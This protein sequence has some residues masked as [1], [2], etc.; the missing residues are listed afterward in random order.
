MFTDTIYWLIIFPNIIHKRGG[1]HVTF[2]NIMPHS[3][4]FI[5][6][7]GDGALNS[8]RYPLFR[9]GYFLLWTSIYVIFQLSLHALSAMIWW[10]YPFLNVSSPW[11][12]LWYVVAGLLQVPCYVG[13]MV[14]LI[15]KRRLFA[16]WFPTT[17]IQV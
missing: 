2:W 17:F 9:I 3:F 12:P 14:A 1:D 11:A 8:M 16:R 6:L 15:L 4:N 7:L 10:P 5:F 13:F